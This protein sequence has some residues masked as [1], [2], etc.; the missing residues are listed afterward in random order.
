MSD[1]PR[2]NEK[3]ARL[4]ETD[5]RRILERAIQLDTVRTNEVSLAELRRVAEEVGISPVALMQAF[6]EHQLG[7]RSSPPLATRIEPVASGWVDR[8]RRL[9][10]PVWLGTCASV[11]GL[12][13]ASMGEDEIAVGTFIATIAGSLVLAIMHR[14]RRRD[15]VEADAAG[16]ATPEQLHDARNQEW[17]LLLDLSAIWAPWSILHAFD[18]A[19]FMAIGGL[20]WGIAVVVGLGIV[21]LVNPKPKLQAPDSRAP[22]T[23]REPE[24]SFS[25]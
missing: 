2:P 17:A 20:A 3:D 22:R 5:V 12:F 19:E 16:M 7:K 25:S 13:S 6:E 14:L 9:L 4:T 15:A 8:A 23:P 21:V 18:E 10:R 11:L 24:A 1:D